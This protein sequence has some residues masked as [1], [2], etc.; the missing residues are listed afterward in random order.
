MKP[1]IK[2]FLNPGAAADR[3]RHVRSNT[4]LEAEEAREAVLAKL[5]EREASIR[6]R[7]LPG[8]LPAMEAMLMAAES[9]PVDAEFAE[10]SEPTSDTDVDLDTPD[11]S[12][13]EHPPSDCQST[14]VA[15]L[16][17]RPGAGGMPKPQKGK[18]N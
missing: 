17:F 16:P 4:K 1:R 18:R 14:D 9:V 15:N 13:T 8:D 5:P 12:D 3:I 11:V 10:T 6:A 2:R 7:V